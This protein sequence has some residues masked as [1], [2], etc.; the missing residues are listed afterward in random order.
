MQDH[1]AQRS[2]EIIV[3]K[4]VSQTTLAYQTL[5]ENIM[6]GRMAQGQILSISFLSELLQLGRSPVTAA[7]QRLEYDGLVHIIPKQ[8]V[9]INA[10]TLD[11]AR[12]IYESRAA[13]EVF[14][15][16]KAFDKLNEEDLVILNSLIDQQLLCGDTWDM[17][18]FMISDT[19]FHRRL[20]LK[21]SNPVLSEMHEHILARIFLFGV[22][23]SSKESRFRGSIE[24]HRQIVDSIRTAD[25]AAFV[26]HVR[27]HILNGYIA[28]TGTY[29]K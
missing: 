5:K 7:C 21:Y 18:T 3:Q 19:E 14:F 1:E 26:Q 8:G 15:A 29:E 28:L 24:E 10:L 23:N 22:K 12:Q 4:K 13:I 27:D 25:K 9:W 17:Y 11:D 20:M 6:R 2:G 16:E